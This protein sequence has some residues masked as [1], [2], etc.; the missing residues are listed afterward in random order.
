[1]YNQTHLAIITVMSR[2]HIQL[3]DLTKLVNRATKKRYL[4]STVSARIRDLS[5]L[6]DTLDQWKGR[7]RYVYY[8][9]KPCAVKYVKDR[10]LDGQKVAA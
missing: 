10:L 3:R 9:C 7:R 1:M 2:G 6:Y 5:G 4:E 8:I